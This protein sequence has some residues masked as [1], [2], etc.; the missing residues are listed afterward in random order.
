MGATQEH[1]DAG[2]AQHGWWGGEMRVGTQSTQ[3][4]AQTQSTRTRE[5]S[6][7]RYVGDEEGFIRSSFQKYFI[8]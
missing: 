8:K 6:N 1:A 5:G 4:G 7:L 2:H 3:N